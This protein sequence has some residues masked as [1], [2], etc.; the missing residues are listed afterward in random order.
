MSSKIG[1]LSGK[2]K[3]QSPLAADPNRYEW[4]SLENAEPNLG[5]P[6]ANGRILAGNTDGTR[7]WTNVTGPQGAQGATGATGPAGAQG[8][9]GPTGLVGPQ[10]A[11]GVAGPTGPRGPQGATGTTGPTGAQGATGVAGPTGPQGIPGDTGP[12]GAQGPRGATGVAGPTGA[13]G[14]QGATGP[15]GAQGLQG[16]TGP[17][18]AQGPQ[19]ATG[20]T[21][22]QGAI[23][24]TGPAGLVDGNQSISGVKTFTQEAAST[25]TSTGTLIVSGNGGIGVGGTINSGASKTVGSHTVGKAVYETDTASY[26]TTAFSNLCL[27]PVATY[28][29]ARI[30]VQAVEGNNVQTSEVSLVQANGSVSYA[31]YAVLTVGDVLYSLAVDISGGNV[32]VRVAGTSAAATAYTAAKA[33]ILV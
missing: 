9:T 31:E 13:Q 1:S 18:G 29:S 25:S 7:F 21:G 17:A 19:G 27:I 20:P 4:L 26:S 2:V 16:A 11:T 8:A 12:T 14:L 30:T 32:R 22:P 5:T 15:T 10:G 3:A 28:R 24:P 23:G 6:D 33:M